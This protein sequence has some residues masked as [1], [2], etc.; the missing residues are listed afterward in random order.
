MALMEKHK[1][2]MPS[3]M[4]LDKWRGWRANGELYGT[5]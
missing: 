4:E 2:I 3:Y 5:G 1:E